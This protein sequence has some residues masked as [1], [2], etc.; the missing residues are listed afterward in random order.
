MGVKEV[1]EGN[2]GGKKQEE[3]K[4][5]R[6]HLTAGAIGLIRNLCGNDEIKTTICLGISSDPSSSSLHVILEGM[7]LY[8][9]NASIQ[10]HGLGALAAM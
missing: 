4:K 6:Q 8:R 9:D 2:Q 10:E 5:Q 1:L 3:T 7:R